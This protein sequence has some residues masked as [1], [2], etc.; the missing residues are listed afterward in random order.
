VNERELRAYLLG[1]VPEEEAVRLEG[2]LLEDDELYRVLESVEDDLF[3]DHARGRLEPPDRAR[4]EARY[5]TDGERQRFARAFAKRVDV[6]PGV[7]VLRPAQT[8]RRWA[9]LG[10]AAAVV[11][12]VSGLLIQRQI[13]PKPPANVPRPGPSFAREVA[14]AVS[15]GTSRAAAEPTVLP[16]A[17][18]VTTIQLRVRLNPGDRF[19]TYAAELRSSQTDARVWSEQG[20]KA[21]IDNG[22]L[23]VAARIPAASMSDGAY[24]VGVRGVRAGAAA[25]AGE[26]LG[27]VPLKVVRVP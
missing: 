9:P 25:D 24:E 26:D 27:F 14:F 4:L 6:A 13:T 16:I 15:L 20:L 19:E 10:A 21:T 1:Q 22:D 7:V 3:D 5:G 23:V 12:A 18:N 11:I 17:R 2:R 8:F